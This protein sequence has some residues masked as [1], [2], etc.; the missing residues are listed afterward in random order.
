M[1]STHR[2]ALVFAALGA[3]AGCSKKVNTDEANAKVKAWAEAGVAPVKK[4]DC[5]AETMKAGTSFQCPVE[6]VSGKTYA[7]VIDVKDDSGNVYM[8][9]A[10]PMSGGA[11][12]ARDIAAAV[13]QQQGKDIVVDCGAEIVE[14]PPD[15]VQCA[16]TQGESHGHMRIKFDETAKDIT[17]TVEP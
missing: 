10:K 13:K 16:V 1:R 2:L 8:H 7:A 3:I 12:L 15:G 6:F 17:W 4:V 14:I 11:Q 9:W 5:P